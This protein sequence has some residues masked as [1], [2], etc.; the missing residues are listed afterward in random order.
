MVA[1][2]HINTQPCGNTSRSFLA[3]DSKGQQRSPC[4]V[5]Y[6]R[7][8]GLGCA[9]VERRFR[10]IRKTEL[11]RPGR[12]L[13]AQ[14]RRQLQGAVEPRGDTRRKDAATVDDDTLI[15]R[16]RAKERQEVK[17]GPVCGCATAFEQARC[18]KN[19]GTGAH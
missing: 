11:N 5:Q 8:R 18:A 2:R 7:R 1:N 19:Q 13:A 10:R 3:T 6:C 12:V 9:R 16:S 17:R 15:H 4:L 14:F